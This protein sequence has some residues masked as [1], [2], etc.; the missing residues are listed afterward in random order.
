VGER[1]YNWNYFNQSL[2]QWDENDGYMDAYDWDVI[3]WGDQPP[4]PDRR[5]NS[6]YSFDFGSAHRAGCQFVMG[7]GSV[8]LI[9]YGIDQATFLAACIRDDGVIGQLD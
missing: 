9:R 6:L 1:N 3:R 7:D 2:L 5:D 8:R 4:I